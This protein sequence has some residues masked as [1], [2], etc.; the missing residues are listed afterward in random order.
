MFQKSNKNQ[1]I[2]PS[3]NAFH[4][5]NLKLTEQPL[6]MP[7]FGYPCTIYVSCLQILV[8]ENL[9]PF[10]MRGQCYAL[11]LMHNLKYKS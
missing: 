10:S 5:K 6:L 3:E 8:S 1:M 2:N 11:I 9:Q 7:L 4:F